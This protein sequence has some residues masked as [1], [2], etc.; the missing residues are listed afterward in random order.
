MKVN[1]LETKNDSTEK[2]IQQVSHRCLRVPVPPLSRPCPALVSP[3]SLSRP[4]PCHALV[5]VTPCP[6]PALCP[7]PSP[8]APF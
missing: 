5:P 4:C 3:L 2:R 6:C 7:V 1:E 8:I